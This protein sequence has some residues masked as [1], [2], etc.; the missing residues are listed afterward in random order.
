[1]GKSITIVGGL[2]AVLL[3]GCSVTRP[4][5]ESQVAQAAV[6]ASRL[7]RLEHAAGTGVVVAKRPDGTLLVLTCRHVIDQG[8]AG[9]KVLAAHPDV[10]AV[11]VEL[12]AAP[13]AR[14]LPLREEPVPLESVSVLLVGFPMAQ[15]P[16]VSRGIL[17]GV[18]VSSP[19]I[20][21][22]SGCPVVDM[23]GRLVGILSQR[24]YWNGETFAAGVIVPIQDLLPWLG[25]T[26][27][28]QG[29]EVARSPGK[30]G[31]RRQ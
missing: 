25:D 23:Q 18:L 24:L 6:A 27:A 12:P 7:L 1:M 19:A 13:D 15:S 10:D 20:P 2:A 17:F 5:S 22:M 30:A 29:I 26:L 3:A 9:V 16:L 21:G 14:A 28:Q 4:L 8:G 31:R 11:L